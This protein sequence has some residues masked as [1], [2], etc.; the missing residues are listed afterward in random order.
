MRWIAAIVLLAACKQP[1]PQCGG[2]QLERATASGAWTTPALGPYGRI[3]HAASGEFHSTQGAFVVSGERVERSTAVAASMEELHSPY[4][5]TAWRDASIFTRLA[6]TDAP[7]HCVDLPGE[8]LSAVLGPGNAILA[9]TYDAA[10]GGRLWL[11]RWCGAPSLVSQSAVQLTVRALTVDAWVVAEYSLSAVLKLEVYDANGV[12]LGSSWE[13]QSATVIRSPT[14]GD[15]LAV[16]E[17]DDVVLLSAGSLQP[18]ERLALPPSGD[19]A[20]G[21]SVPISVACHGQRVCQ[22]VVLDSRGTR[23]V[24]QASVSDFSPIPVGDCLD[25]GAG[26][27]ACDV[28]VWRVS[29]RGW[30]LDTGFMD[31]KALRVAGLSVEGERLTLALLRP[32]SMPLLAQSGTDGW[33]MEALA[34]VAPEGLVASS[35][36]FFAWIA[37]APD[38]TVPSSAVVALRTRR[39]STTSEVWRRERSAKERVRAPVVTLASGSWN[40]NAPEIVLVEGGAGCTISYGPDQLDCPGGSADWLAVH[41]VNP[42]VWMVGNESS[43]NLM[44]GLEVS[45]TSMGRERFDHLERAS[46]VP[47]TDCVQADAVVGPGA[48]LSAVCLDGLVS[49]G[50]LLGKRWSVKNSQVRLE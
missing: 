14:V 1:T 19:G 32:D 45:S 4:G 24:G 34:G 48:A 23:L 37:I 5:F 46:H 33:Q 21:T 29:S 27:V 35:G 3:L 31:E 17:G 47:A 30:Q 13:G 50:V 2:A 15:W 12:R 11:S 39:G 16:T 25:V 9:T 26:V 6:T 18:L 20:S 36:G 22:V 28:G 43:T 38:S 40:P 44:C 8:V 41:P 49:E 42:S 7:A 10:V